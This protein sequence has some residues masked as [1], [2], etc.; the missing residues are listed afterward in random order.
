MSK[1]DAKADTVD[2]NREGFHLSTTIT[3]SAHS[4]SHSHGERESMAMSTS[5]TLLPHDRQSLP[6]E[7]HLE[8]WDC[9]RWLAGAF[10]VSKA[11]FRE[12]A[13]RDTERDH[14]SASLCV[15]PNCVPKSFE[16]PCASGFPFA[17]ST[18]Y[19]RVPR[20]LIDNL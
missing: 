15:P 17:P 10:G 19:Q 13:S 4:H 12:E 3:T 5:P 1:I 8:A 9:R 18:T 16:A 2:I 11:S 14:R 7:T 6:I 20:K